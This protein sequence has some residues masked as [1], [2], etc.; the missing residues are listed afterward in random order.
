MNDFPAVT[1]RRNPAWLAALVLAA[2]TG[3]AG[4]GGG[5]S[6]ADASPAGRGDPVAPPD[7]PGHADQVPASPAAGQSRAGLS[8]PVYLQVPA[9]G[10]IVAL[11][12]MEPTTLDGGKKYPLVLHSHGFSQSRSTSPDCPSCASGLDENL[13]LL[14][15]NGY[16]VISIDER[17]H[18]ESSGT[19]RL[20]D[21]DYEGKDLLAIL[22]WAEVRLDWLAY[23]PSVDGRDPR[24]LIAGA[25]GGSYGGAFQLLINAIDPRRRLDAIVPEITFYSLRYALQPNDVLRSSFD[26]GLFGAGLSSGSGVDRAR[27]DPFVPS[28]FVD[29]L[30]NNRL[31]DAA[32][33]YLDYHSHAYFCEGRPVATNGPG[34]VPELAPRRPPQVHA[35]FFQGMRDPI[36][37]FDQAYW[38]AQCLREAGG[39]VRLLSYQAGHNL[40]TPFLDAG[41][42]VFQPP[43]H[44]VNDDCGRLDVHVATL[45]FF[46]EHLKGVRGAADPVPRN[47]ISLAAGDAVAVDEIT[48]GR[49]GVEKAI[50]ATTVLM[51]VPDVPVAV[52]LGIVGGPEGDVIAGLPQLQLSVQPAAGVPGEPIVFAG[53]GHM[54]AS[55]PGVWDLVDNQLTPLRGA[56]EFDLQMVGI[57]ERLAPGDRIALLLYGGHTQYVVSGS[58]N[59]A[60]PT[61]MPVTV[62]GRVWVPMLGPLPSAD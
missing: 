6:S 5:S 47:C 59:A 15:D 17:G 16:G 32:R 62:Q 11:T 28:F 49:R 8:Y 36:F 48:T 50:P 40:I 27:Y 43:G 56:G 19:I 38:N 37:G 10:D 46:E 61:I 14:V 39:D 58:V 26:V 41:G 35:M 3:L 45:A 51:G 18:G 21:P 60:S 42:N 33:D 29:A 54:R 44:L 31:N 24:N 52:D 22:D 23:G 12:V 1:A 25:V 55:V 30:A 4:C 7:A 9:T 57:G 53:I 20:M 13:R 2:A 34:L